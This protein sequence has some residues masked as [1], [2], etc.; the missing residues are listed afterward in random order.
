[1]SQADVSQAEDRI[2]ET[3]RQ[4]LSG[5]NPPDPCGQKER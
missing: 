5:G 3:V 2:T 1:M 4:C